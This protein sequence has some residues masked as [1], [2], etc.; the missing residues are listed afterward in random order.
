VTDEAT[1][2]PVAAADDSPTYAS[3]TTPPH[4]AFAEIER[5]PL[6]EDAISNYPESPF[7]HAGIDST[8]TVRCRSGSA[9]SVGSESDFVEI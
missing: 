1:V 2:P 8:R 4:P 6:S 9:S 7:V 5:L 3:I